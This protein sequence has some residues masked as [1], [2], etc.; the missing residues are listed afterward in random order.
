MP[1]KKS[2]SKKSTKKTSKKKK[3]GTPLHEDFRDYTAEELNE[4]KKNVC[5]AHHCPY[6]GKVSSSWSKGK[7]QPISNAI[8][9][10]ILMAEHSRGC[11]PDVCTHWNEHPTKS[12]CRSQESLNEIFSNSPV[13]DDYDCYR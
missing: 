4:I 7:H 11:M 3:P 13:S 8:C 1:S 12:A 10:Y 5:I 6:V 2:S 9:N